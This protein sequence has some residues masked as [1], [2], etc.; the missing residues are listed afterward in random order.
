[1]WYRLEGADKEW[2]DDDGRRSAFYLNLGPDKYR[3]HV[4]ACTEGGEWSPSDTALEFIIA[5]AWFQTNWFLALCAVAASLIVWVLHRMRMQR[6]SKAMAARFD[7]RLS[8]RTRIARDLHDTSLNSLRT[9]TVETNSLTQALKRATEN[10]SI[11]RSMALNFVV[12]GDAR[13]THPIVRDEIYRI[14]YEAI[15]NA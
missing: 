12:V 14:G 1:M 15:L 5:P 2:E 7:E 6:V 4:N 13:E 10:C 11:P 9:S 3:F 8:E